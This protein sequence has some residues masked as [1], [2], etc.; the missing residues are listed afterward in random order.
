MV[1]SFLQILK[2]SV[3]KLLPNAEHKVTPLPL[4]AILAQ[5]GTI[6]LKGIIWI[7]M[8]RIESKAVQAL[9]QGRSTMYSVWL[10][11]MY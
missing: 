1:V 6:L 9:C 8:F 10:L 3:E 2:E 7:G 4:P 11:S 5:G